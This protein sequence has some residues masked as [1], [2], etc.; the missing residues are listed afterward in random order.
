M[1]EPKFKIDY[2]KGC[3]KN[4]DIKDINNINQCCFDTLNAFEGTVS[5]NDSRNTEGGA[6]CNKC[7]DESKLAMGRDLCEFRLSAYPTW[8]QA[9]HY[10]PA[11]LD[12]EQDID[13]AKAKCMEACKSSPYK[14]ECQKNCKI[15]SDAV[16][17]MEGYS[18]N[19]KNKEDRNMFNDD[20]FYLSFTV[21]SYVV[22]IYIIT[23]A[24]EFFKKN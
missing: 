4:Y 10:F 19:I 16:E 12:S 1:N 22:V 7:L 18:F 20:C 6:N 14:G 21:V 15:D 9:P 23:K 17:T 8:V 3:K 5:T 24:V 11:L 13:S 2:C